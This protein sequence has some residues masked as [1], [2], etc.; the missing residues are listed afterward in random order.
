M[1]VLATDTVLVQETAATAVRFSVARWLRYAIP[2]L[3]VAAPLALG[4]TPLRFSFPL[5]ALCWLF[6]LLWLADSLRLGSLRLAPH[7]L[8]LPVGL[9]LVYTAIPWIGGFA[10]NSGGARLEW[11]RWLAYA[12]V[13]F[14]SVQVF[15]TPDRLRRLVKFAAT[16][17][18]AVAAFAILQYLTAGGKIYWVIEP[19]RGGW[20]F[21]PYVNRNHFA[22]LMELLMPLALGLA[23]LWRNSLLHRLFW[24]CFALVMAT[25]VM[26]SGSR[27]G[28]IGMAA[29]VAAFAFAAASMRGGRR[30]I[31]GLV[32]AV[33]ITAGVALALDQ[34]HTFDRYKSV[35]HPST[36]QEEEASGKRLLA[37]RDTF[38]LIR[39]NWLVGSG[40]DG[41]VVLFPAVRSFYTDKI[42]THAHND[43]LQ[44][45][46]ETGLIGAMIGFW[47]L[48]AG[49][50]EAIRNLA[51]CR[52]SDTGILLAGVASG[53]VALL[54]HGL[55]DFNFHVPANAANFS[56]LAAVL[57]RRG[58]DE[59]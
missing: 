15:N 9:L 30:V 28:F 54:V 46:A 41:F 24:T 40:L 58:W 59:N 57:T 11:L 43:F 25:S 39:Q 5:V 27:G 38:T 17:G 23:L 34:G 47:I 22:G 35:L 42:W 36:I 37:W 50:R 33:L 45:L 44:F 12:S 16:G 1:S 49:G 21:G 56:V 51:R 18:F 20:V 3:L 31:I 19:E 13:A 52:G 4:S 2:T 10:A 8:L 48:Y 26:L 32:V 55:V 29:G 7:A 14:V 53:C 6:F